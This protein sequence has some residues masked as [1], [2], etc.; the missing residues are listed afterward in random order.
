[1]CPLCAAAALIAGAAS[2]RGLAALAK[3]G[4]ARK[5]RAK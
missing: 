5:E 1:M 4:R 3:K 2:A